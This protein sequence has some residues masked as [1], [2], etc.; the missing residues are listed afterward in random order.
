MQVFIFLFM[1]TKI[2]FNGTTHVRKD[3]QN[4]AIKLLFI[5]GNGMTHSIRK[6]KARVSIPNHFVSRYSFKRFADNIQ[7][8][9][10]SSPKVVKIS[11]IYFLHRKCILFKYT[12]WCEQSYLH[13]NWAVIPKGVYLQL[14]EN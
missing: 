9:I 4:Q 13:D 1:H 5:S 2:H 10:I 14:E 6:V 8:L 11:K 12:L 3:L 7:H